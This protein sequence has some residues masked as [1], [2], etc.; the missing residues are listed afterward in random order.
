MNKLM[1]LTNVAL[2]FT[3]LAGLFSEIFFASASLQVEEM[4]NDPIAIEQGF[5]GVEFHEPSSSVALSNGGKKVQIF[6][7][8][9]TNPEFVMSIEFGC[10]VD[11]IEFTGGGRLLVS[12]LRGGR[13]VFLVDTAKTEIKRLPIIPCLLYSAGT[14]D[15]THLGDQ[16][17]G[18]SSL[19]GFHILNLAKEDRSWVKL[20]AETGRPYSAEPV[21]DATWVTY[22]WDNKLMQN[23]GTR[24][25]EIE[26]ESP[27]R[28]DYKNGI[29]VCGSSSSGKIHVF[30]LNPVGRDYSFRVSEKNSYLNDI[31]IIKAGSTSNLLITNRD[32]AEIIVANF[33]GDVLQVIELPS[34][35]RPSLIQELR[36]GNYLVTDA[37]LGAYLLRLGDNRY[38]VENYF[39]DFAN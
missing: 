14:T 38:L 6:H 35:S 11:A 25:Q 31:E 4:G 26:I 7:D 36:T 34:G 2:V 8:I 37:N 13:G 24:V 10:Y 12:C 17:Y 18:F 15:V 33:E 5:Y 32:E 9:G 1:F 16:R 19:C 20:N 23:V 22:P 27:Y 28:C 29:A 39:S 3:L 30:E 21:Q